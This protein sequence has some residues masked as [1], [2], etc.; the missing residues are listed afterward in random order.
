VLHFLTDLGLAC[1]PDVHLVRTVRHLAPELRL[2]EDKIPN[3]I[4][5]ILINRWVR[6]LVEAAYGSFTPARLRYVDKIL[7][8]I[9]RRKII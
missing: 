2:K 8:E 5:S 4:E 1:K 3:L 6:S 7:M 9:S